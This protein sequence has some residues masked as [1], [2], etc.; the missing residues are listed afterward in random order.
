ML[1][2]AGLN[3]AQGGGASAEALLN[4]LAQLE[5]NT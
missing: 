2:Q 1:N 3:Q 5:R 4:G